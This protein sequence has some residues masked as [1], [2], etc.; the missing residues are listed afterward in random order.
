MRPRLPTPKIVTGSIIASLFLLVIFFQKIHDDLSPPFTTKLALAKRTLI[1]EQVLPYITFGW[2]NI[3]TDFYWIRAI[4]DFVAWNGK[5]SFFLDYFKNIS[6][7]DPRF[8][9]PYLFAILA[10]PQNKDIKT[11]DEIAKISQ[12]GID[13][14]SESWKIP[15]YLG[16]KYF[17]FTKDYEKA[18]PYLAIAASKKNA[19]D[20]VYLVYSTYVAR[21]APKRIRSE[22]DVIAAQSL[23]RVIYNN[24]DNE[25]IKQMASKGI[26]EEHLNQL[27]EKGYKTRYK[28]YPNTIDELLKTNFIRLPAELLEN[29]DIIINPKDGSFRIITKK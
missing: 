14:I 13:T 27:L 3:I 16:T 4:Q 25:T 7:L 11:L 12:R 9:Y 1:P 22:E 26:V 8:E 6:A 15:F 10:V 21:K 29:F 17:I 2:R 23:I 5:E 20:G 18:E 28:K 19:P 24:T